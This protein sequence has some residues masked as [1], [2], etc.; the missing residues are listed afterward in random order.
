MMKNNPDSLDKAEELKMPLAKM[1]LKYFAEPNDAD[2]RKEVTE[3]YVDFLS[4]QGLQD[5]TVLCDET[6]NTE[7]RIA[8][9]ELWVD[10][11][12]Q[13]VE[14]EVFT[15]IPLRLSPAPDA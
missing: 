12:V 4:K 3:D 7:E 2:T 14:D 15:Y 13:Y 6:N 9:N 1:L 5:F 10:I 11:A 8:A